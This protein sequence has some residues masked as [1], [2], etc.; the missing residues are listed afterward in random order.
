MVS[1]SLHFDQSLLQKEVSLIGGGH[2]GHGAHGG[3]G[4]GGGIRMSV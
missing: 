3:Y 4:K 1:H 2:E